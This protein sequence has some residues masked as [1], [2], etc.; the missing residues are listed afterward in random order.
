MYEAPDELARKVGILG[1]FSDCPTTV[2][3]YANCMDLK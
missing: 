3:N 1:I 2:T